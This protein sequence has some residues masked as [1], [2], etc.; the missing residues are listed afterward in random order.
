MFSAA[1]CILRYPVEENISFCQCRSYQEAQTVLSEQLGYL[2][3]HSTR[4]CGTLFHPRDP[5]G[6]PR[7]W[8]LVPTRQVVAPGLEETLCDK[9]GAGNHSSDL[10]S[11]DQQRVSLRSLESSAF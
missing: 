3:L 7:R 10:L 6:K 4:R 11:L 8:A 2:H 9:H 1:F 5:Q